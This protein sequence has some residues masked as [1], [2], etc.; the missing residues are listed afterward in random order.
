MAIKPFR[1]GSV[2]ESFATNALSV[3]NEYPSIDSWT[4]RQIFYRMVAKQYVRNTMSQYQTLSKH[5]VR[6]RK[7]G[8]F[9]YS[10]MVDL[11]REIFSNIRN[12]RS[13]WIWDVDYKL[14][15]IIEPPYTSLNANNLQENITLIV[16][17]K[18]AL[19]G[20]FR[21]TIGSMCVLVTC[22]GFNS[23]TQLK[24]ISNLLS[25][26]KRNVNCYVFSDYDP[27][28]LDIQRNFKVQCEE[29]GL[30]F[31]TFERIALTEKLID[32]YSLPGVP[33]KTDDP[34]TDASWNGR[35]VVELDALEPPVL[36]QLIK[37]VIAK[38]FDKEIYQ[39]LRKIHKVQK[40]RAKKRYAKG[41]MRVAEELIN[42]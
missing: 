12:Y 38:D 23:L 37:D 13:D 1:K 42:S 30:E 15:D 29:L 33:A 6:A 41:L 3:I 40:R 39:W 36:V 16:L 35:E 11:D 17:E 26:E 19:Q 25:E 20:I 22:K 32:K 5:L 34:R 27:S 28:G 10:K 21:S 14:K 8:V 4:L 31:N 18:K 7:L 9:P 2:G 24:S